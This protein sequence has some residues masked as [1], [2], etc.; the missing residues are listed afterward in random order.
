MSNR[1]CHTRQE[2]LA[3]FFLLCPIVIIFGAFPLAD[4]LYLQ[5]GS[6]S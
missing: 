2:E 3:F 4:F 6:R 5:L 1:K